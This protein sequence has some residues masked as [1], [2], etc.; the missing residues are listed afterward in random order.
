MGATARGRERGARRRRA[1]LCMCVSRRQLRRR[2]CAA[3][4]GARAACHWT[5]WTRRVSHPVLTGHAS[6]RTNRT[7]YPFPPPPV[8]SP[9]TSTTQR[10]GAGGSGRSV[11]VVSTEWKVAIGGRGHHWWRQ[12]TDPA[13]RGPPG[14][15]GPGSDARA[16]ASSRTKNCTPGTKR[17][18]RTATS[19]PRRS[20]PP[21]LLLR[22]RGCIEQ[23]NDY[24]KSIE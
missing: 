21:R 3:S 22:E 4:P 24:S 6:P 12:E 13:P 8:K 11:A 1:A 17:W 2:V 15:V 23:L 5:H 19:A 20:A 14:Q 18:R 16:C 7:R 10:N 9:V